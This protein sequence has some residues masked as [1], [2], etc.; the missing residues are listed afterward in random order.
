MKREMKVRYEMKCPRK[1]CT[2]AIVEI[3]SG[4]DRPGF[5]CKKHGPVTPGTSSA[6]ASPRCP[7]CGGAIA[8]VAPKISADSW[9]CEDCGPVYPEAEERVVTA[10]KSE[11]PTAYNTNASKPVWDGEGP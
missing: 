10:E 3:T 1:D 5:V 2:E 4:R 6:H 7:K 11:P 8:L 9:Y